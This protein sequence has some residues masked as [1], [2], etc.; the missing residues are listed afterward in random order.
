MTEELHG[1][2]VGIAFGCLRKKEQNLFTFT[3]DRIAPLPEGLSVRQSRIVDTRIQTFHYF[4]TQG[5]W[6][7]QYAVFTQQ[8]EGD[9]GATSQ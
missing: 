8:V 4:V 6:I 1:A 7:D 9:F 2:Q 5:V 3:Q